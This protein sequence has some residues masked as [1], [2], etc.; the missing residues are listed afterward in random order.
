MNARQFLSH[1]QLSLEGGNEVEVKIFQELLLCV[2]QGNIFKGF[3]KVLHFEITGRMPADSIILQIYSIRYC[4]PHIYTK[5]NFS[6][7]SAC[8]LPMKWTLFCL[9]VQFVH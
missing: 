6:E 7:L 2:F 3:I 4:H 9:V 8:S 5:S 1:H